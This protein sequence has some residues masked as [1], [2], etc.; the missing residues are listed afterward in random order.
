[1]WITLAFV[2]ALV[3]PMAAEHEIYNRYTVLGYVKD[4]GGAPLRGVSVS[5]TREKTGF[6]YRGETDA[7]GLYLIV[8][9]I[10]DESAGERLRLAAGE[11]VVTFIARFDPANHAEE[12]G[13][14]LDFHGG[15]SV[16]RAAWFLPT[17]RR[18]VT[19]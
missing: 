12:R 15:R 5:L 6:S 10:G 7:A 4:S 17:L 13:T 1:M 19:E 14:R 2:L 9:R 18:V 3:G 16:E 8:A 11:H